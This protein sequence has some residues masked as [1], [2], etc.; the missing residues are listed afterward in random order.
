MTCR[1]YNL[2]MNNKENNP[3]NNP[4]TPEAP[5]SNTSYTYYSNLCAHSGMTPSR[6]HFARWLPAQHA[7]N[8]Y[9]ERRAAVRKEYR[10]WIEDNGLTPR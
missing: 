2:S 3:N 7:R 1:R 9:T 10:Q 6:A 8:A 4:S 5:M